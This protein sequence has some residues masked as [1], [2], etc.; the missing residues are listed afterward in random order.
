MKSLIL[1]ML[2]FV[3]VACANETIEVVPPVVEAPVVEPPVVEDPVTEDPVMEDP[4]EE[5]E[6]AIEESSPEP[7][8]EDEESAMDP[9]ESETMVDEEEEEMEE[10]A[11]DL[12][13]FDSLS[14]A[15]FDGRDGR[16]AYVA[17]DGIV[18]DVTESPRWPNGNHNG[19]QAGQDLSRQ[20]PQ[21]H[22]ADMR[23][24]RFPVVGTYVE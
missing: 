3:L 19:F 18:Y 7:E 14:L 1:L 5:E 23:I 20:I 2:A 17:I 21:N 4:L 12:P 11:S 6:S 9:E 13:V 24:E 16:K 22:R 15:E 8:Q 10:S